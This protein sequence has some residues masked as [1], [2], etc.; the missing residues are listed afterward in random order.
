MNETL[1]FA[2]LS[3]L[4]LT[5]RG[6]CN[7]ERLA[8]DSVRLFRDARETAERLAP[9]FILYGGDLFEARRQA[10]PHLDLARRELQRTR[11]PWFVIA[12]NHDAR[13]RTTED[14]Y[15]RADFVRIFSGRGPRDGRSYWS[16]SLPG[17]PYV[18]IG[19]DT[20][21]DYTS[22]G[23]VGPEQ[24]AWLREELGRLTGRRAIVFMHHPAAIFDPIVTESPALSI[25]RLDDHEEVRELLVG[26]RG[27]KLVVS[28]HNHTRRHAEIGGLHFV[29]CPSINSWPPMFTVFELSRDRVVFEFVAVGGEREE[30]EAYAGLT[31]PESTWLTGF[32]DAAAVADYFARAPASRALELRHD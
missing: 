9:D 19:L 17:T 13:Y 24:S 8:L 5:D 1:R 23:M 22:A 27:V 11:V 20:S 25:Y 10:L 15:A 6:E 26:H 12:G 3:D 31:H 14:G 21:R 32:P 28:G 16:H 18:L 7:R 30:R 4:H 2:V 29:G